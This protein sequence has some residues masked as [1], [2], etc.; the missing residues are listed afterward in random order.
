MVVIAVEVMVDH[1]LPR[2]FTAPLSISVEYIIRGAH[3]SQTLTGFPLVTTTEKVIAD[4]Y[5]ASV[6]TVSG[7]D[8]NVLC[9]IKNLFVSHTLS[10]GYGWI[11]APVRRYGIVVITQDSD[12]QLPETLVRILVAPPFMACLFCT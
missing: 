2:L 10:D 1:A 8:R 3:V 6:L 7:R 4:D 5:P 12:A 9:S 11:V